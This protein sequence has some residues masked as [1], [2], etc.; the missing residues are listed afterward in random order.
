MHAEYRIM[1]CL[2]EIKPF[3]WA[4]WILT[5]LLTSLHTTRHYIM[6]VSAY[7]ICY[8]H[9][10]ER[11]W[12]YLLHRVV[13]THYGKQGVEKVETY[14]PTVL[15]ARSLTWRCPQGRGLSPDSRAPSLGPSSSWR[16]LA[17]LRPCGPTRPVSASVFLWPS[18]LFVCASFS[19]LPLLRTPVTGLGTRPGPG[20]SHLE[21]FNYIHQDPVL[22]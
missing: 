1:C 6:Y 8:C 2:S 14:S 12:L 16:L 11:T 3:N 19:C 15:E 17:A 5:T 9:H 21:I 4:P 22:K 7:L 20:R 13:I 10:P 18:S